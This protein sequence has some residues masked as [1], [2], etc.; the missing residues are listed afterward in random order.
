MKYDPSLTT[1]YNQKH[2][3]DISTHGYYKEKKEFYLE[4]LKNLEGK[5]RKILDIACN[6]GALTKNYEKYGDVLGIDINKNAIAKCKKRGVKCLLSTV[7]DL[8]KKYDNYFDIIIAGDIIEHIFNTDDFLRNIHKKLKKGGILLLTTANVASIGR[9][10][11]F[12]FGK[13]PFLEYSTELPYKE[14]NVGHIRYYTVGDMYLQM[15]HCGFVNTQVLGDRINLTEK[16][17]IP[18]VVSKHLPTISRYMHVVAQ[19]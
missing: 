3:S 9:R 18:R 16:L 13:N 8:P 11:M 6:D 10:I 12:L 1:F 5:D 4:N 2:L 15:N 17:Y 14:L 7:E 19:K